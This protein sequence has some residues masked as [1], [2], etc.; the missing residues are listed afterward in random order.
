MNA[1]STESQRRLVLVCASL[2]AGGAERVIATMANHWA[3]QGRQVLLLTLA[4][5]ANDHYSLHPGV[6]RV[7]LDLQQPTRGL[8]AKLRANLTRLRALRRN[9]RSA[10]PTAVISFVEQMNVSV[11]A[12]LMWS[13]IPVLV[14]ERVDPRHY[15]V[16]WAWRALRRLLYSRAQAV[17]VQTAAVAGWMKTFVAHERVHVVANPVRALPPPTGFEPS[18]RTIL[19][20]GRLHN[21]KGFDLLLRSFHA[22]GLANEGW[23]LRILGEGSD[24]KSLAALASQLG[25]TDS[26]D[27]PGVVSDPEKHMHLGAIFVLSSRYEGFPN[28][29][30][31]AM[32]M[33]MAVI[34]TDCPSGP[35]EIVQHERNG[36]LVPNESVDDL[37]RALRELADD[38]K[39][40]GE[41]GRA[42]LEV[43]RR[44]DADMIM[45]AWDRLVASAQT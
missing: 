8:V 38:E 21:Q 22:S 20:M 25:I 6:Q 15:E 31:E 18:R 13:G 35:A 43:R 36:L 33:G 41:F 24:R 29:L 39:R 26:L 28:A 5:H 34:A 12:A 44:Y 3:A 9:I 27:M 19:A 42:A 1:V 40:R 10:Q 45:R 16:A 23:H 30:L 4:Q 7:G 2:H 11:L 17:V 37:A 32:A 14:S